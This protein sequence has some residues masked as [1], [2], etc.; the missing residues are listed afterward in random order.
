MD[1]MTETEDPVVASEKSTASSPET[2][3]QSSTSPAL[4]RTKIAKCRRYKRNLIE[5]W[6]ENIDR[7][8]GKMYDTDSD[9]DRVAVAYDWSATKAKQAGLFSAFPQVRLKAKNDA[10]K[11]GTSV[12]AK[13]LNDTLAVAEVASAMDEVLPDCINAAGFGLVMCKFE[14][15]Q[16]TKDISA[17]MA[18]ATPATPAAPA[19]PPVDGQPAP[20]PQ[21]QTANYVYSKRFICD[22]L[23]PS[24]ALWDLSFAG[25]NFN[26][27]PWTGHTGRMHWSEAKREFKLADADKGDICTTGTRSLYDRLNNNEELDRMADTEIVEYDEIFY[28]RYLFHDDENSFEAIQRMVFVHGKQIPVINELWGGQ[29]RVD[30]EG[31]PDPKG[32]VILGSCKP[33]LQFLTLTYLSD[34][35]IPPSDSAM[36]RP[37]VEEMMAARTDMMLNRRYSRP[38]RWFNNNLVAPEMVTSLMRGDWQGLIPINGQGDRAIGEVARAAFPREEYESDRVFKNELQETWSIGGAQGFGGGSNTQI[39][40]AEEARNAQS[41]LNTRVG[42]ERARTVKLLCNIAE[43]FAG[44]LSLHGDWTP[45][46]E[47]ALAGLDMAKLPSYYTYTVRTDAS[48]LQTAEQRYQRLESYYNLTAKSGMVDEVPVLQEMA[49]LI[50]IDENLV[51]APMQKGIDPANVSLRLDAES[52]KDPIVIAMLMQ[53]GQLPSQDM[54]EKAKA[55]IMASI[56]AAQPIVPPGVPGAGGPPGAAPAVPAQPQ[57]AALPGG[58]TPNGAPLQ[59]DAHPEIDMASMVNKRHQDGK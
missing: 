41:N 14:S 9:E 54:L 2:A 48:V 46:E 25:S 58:P 44:L 13:K 17:L 16:E 36:G 39:R 56:Q 20:E 35:A 11:A 6:R 52:L 33:P 57:P 49:S 8:R 28:W 34:E 3:G 15:R 42:Y 47:Q 27:S 37:Q 1:S 32:E 26:R 4:W 29:K 40:T 50:D 5:G 19:A 45:D 24:D 18:P 55:F 53:T 21:P 10:Y 30:P 51:K 12:F 23:S 22:R 7:R 59:A 31:N 38:M 43:V